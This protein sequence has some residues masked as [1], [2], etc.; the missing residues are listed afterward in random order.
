MRVASG[1]SHS[2][3]ECF[4]EIGQVEALPEKPLTL[5]LSPAEPGGERTMA[6][7]SRLVGF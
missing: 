7:A 5:A 1:K 2:L 4:A 6:V 3:R